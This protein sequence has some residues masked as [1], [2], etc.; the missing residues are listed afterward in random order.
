MLELGCQNSLAS[1]DLGLTEAVASVAMNVAHFL[2]QRYQ[3]PYVGSTYS[4]IGLTN[5]LYAKD[6]A[7][8]VAPCKL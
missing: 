6:F 4:S 3:E 1:L 5:D 8:E 7:A 2:T